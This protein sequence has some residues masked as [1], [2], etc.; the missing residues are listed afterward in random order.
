VA[1]P[2]ALW[3]PINILQQKIHGALDNLKEGRKKDI[4]K[5]DENVFHSYPFKLSA[6]NLNVAFKSR[7]TIFLTIVRAQMIMNPI[8]LFY[9]SS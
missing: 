9:P 5:C 6:L 3:Y 4:L 1:I 7:S 8:L 2:N